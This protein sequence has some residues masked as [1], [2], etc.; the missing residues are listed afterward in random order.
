LQQRDIDGVQMGQGA[1]SAPRQQHS[2]RGAAAGKR[3]A[4]GE[5]LPDEAPMSRAQGSADGNFFLPL[6]RPRQQQ[7]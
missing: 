6:R 1:R 5:H 3:H 4:F 7:I 2:E